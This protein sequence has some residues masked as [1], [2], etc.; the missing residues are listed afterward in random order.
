MVENHVSKNIYIP[1]FI[2]YYSF[3]I[4]YIV[5]KISLENNTQT[6]LLP[7]ILILLC[8]ACMYTLNN[9]MIRTPAPLGELLDM[10]VNGV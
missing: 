9:I 5:L 1:V 7:T 6:K 10:L 4:Q 8:K 2:I 3:K